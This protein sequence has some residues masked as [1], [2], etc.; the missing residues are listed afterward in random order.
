MRSGVVL[1]VSVVL[2]CATVP[3]TT[4]SD[5]EDEANPWRDTGIDLS[6]LREQV[7]NR[8]CSRSDRGF[9][10]CIGAVQ[11]VLDVHG[12]DLHLVPF[13][14]FASCSGSALFFQTT[15]CGAF[16]SRRRRP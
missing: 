7:D 1:C 3:G 8:N 14:D 5:D 15:T 9:F 12:G 6:F 10:S 4:W 2:L 13:A 11:R 16:C